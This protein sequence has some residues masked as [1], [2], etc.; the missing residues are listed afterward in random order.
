[1][2]TDSN[3]I[4][5]LYDNESRGYYIIWRPMFVIASGDTPQAALDELRTT[6]HYAVESTVDAYAHERKEIDNETK[7]TP[8]RTSY[9]RN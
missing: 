2:N 6:A 8:K 3:E 1:M 9:L 4:E 5:M 7:A